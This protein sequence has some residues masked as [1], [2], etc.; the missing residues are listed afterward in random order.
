VNR[1]NALFA[2]AILAAL[3]APAFAAAPDSP[4]ATFTALCADTHVDFPAVSAAADASGWKAQE[5]PGDTTMAGVTVSDHTNRVKGGNASMRLFAWRG[6]TAKG[7]KVSAC[8]LHVAKAELSAVAAGAQSWVGFAPQ[9][10]TAS[11]AIF[12]LSDA[13]DG[14]HALAKADYDAAAAGPGMEILTVSSD[15]HGAILDLLKIQK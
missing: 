12:R 13:P 6:T 5:A 3:A 14:R 8:T 10:T 2:S 7:V 11:N 9:E 1:I 4:V 15:G